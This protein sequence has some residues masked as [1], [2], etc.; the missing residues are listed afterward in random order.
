MILLTNMS[1]GWLMVL[2]NNNKKLLEISQL[3]SVMLSRIDLS[4]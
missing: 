3:H 2:L 1:N 4:L